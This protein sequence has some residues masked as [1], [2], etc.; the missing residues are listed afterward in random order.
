MTEEHIVVQIDS[1]QA[2]DLDTA[3]LARAIAV[4]LQG[5]GQPAGEVTLVVTD[6]RAASLT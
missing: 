2:D 1:D 3:D 5:E 6:D 4:T